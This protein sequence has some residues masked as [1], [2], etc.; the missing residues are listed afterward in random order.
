MDPELTKKVGK[1][2]VDVA[3]ESVDVSME[4]AWKVYAS[5]GGFRTFIIICVLRT[6]A[7]YHEWYNERLK[8]EFAATDPI[9]QAERHFE[10]M[11]QIY[12]MAMVGIVFEACK[13]YYNE[14][15]NKSMGSEIH[16]MTLFKIFAAPVNLFFD[17][18]PIGKILKIFTDDMNVFNGRFVREI[19]IIIEIGS[20]IV[21]VFSVLTVLSTWDILFGF[22]FVIIIMGLIS[23]PYLAADN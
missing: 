6:I 1:L 2:L 18:T 11:R 14:R 17:I 3:E 4:T 13:N 9:A 20:H 8:N 5:I 7:R 19:D 15:R 10:F 21:V 12:A 23:K 22:I 16:R